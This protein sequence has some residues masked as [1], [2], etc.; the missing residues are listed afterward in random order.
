MSPEI[1]GIGGGWLDREISTGAPAML[2]RHTMNM[3]SPGPY[4]FGRWST[5]RSCL[6]R[7]TSVF[8]AHGGAFA[9]LLGK[10]IGARWWASLPSS[11]R[12]N[13]SGPVRLLTLGVFSS[14]LYLGVYC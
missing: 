13:A 3:L 8:L 5:A 14:W 2:W 12:R 6:R 9:G 7:C 1:M 4:T 10:E 11:T